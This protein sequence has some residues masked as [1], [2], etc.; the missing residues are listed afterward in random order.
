MNLKGKTWL[1]NKWTSVVLSMVTRTQN[2][3]AIPF[4]WTEGDE[5]SVEELENKNIS[6]SEG[7]ELLSKVGTGN[8]KEPQA[9]PTRTLN[10]NQ[11]K[12]DSKETDLDQII[13]NKGSVD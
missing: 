1:I 11:D 13:L 6:S 7:T 2:K 3:V 12:E 5:D 4:P 9:K 8:N 10:R